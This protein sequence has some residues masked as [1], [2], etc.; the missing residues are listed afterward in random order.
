MFSRN[1]PKRW[2]I[3]ALLSAALCAAL[4][5]PGWWHR[6]EG[7]DENHAH[8]VA[9]ERHGHRHPHG[10]SHSHG[11]Q[12]H[13]SHSTKVD[14][15]SPGQP[16]NED[17]WHQHVSLLGWTWMVWGSE[18]SVGAMSGRPEKGRS[19]LD[20][21]DEFRL[22][23]FPAIRT[24]DHHWTCSQ[25]GGSIDEQLPSWRSGPPVPPPRAG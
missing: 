7:G 19:L 6:H 21:L 18:D 2:L 12:S 3:C 22:V 5:T 11:S 20:W 25:F 4:V 1:P 10:H 13:H 17:R 14:N 23:P 24:L 9:A 15:G 16:V 8:G